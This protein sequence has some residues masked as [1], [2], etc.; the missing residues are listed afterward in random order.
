MISRLRRSERCDEREREREGDDWVPFAEVEGEVV[1]EVFEKV[2]YKRGGEL[3]EGELD[4]VFEEAAEVP[5]HH[6]AQDVGVVG[7]HPKVEP[8]TRLIIII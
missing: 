5:L 3:H 2:I 8:R 1:D 7:D 4:D 6:G